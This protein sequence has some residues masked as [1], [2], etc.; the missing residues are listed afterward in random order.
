MDTMNDLT[1]LGS[2]RVLYRDPTD[3]QMIRNLSLATIALTL[4]CLC[5]LMASVYL[6]WR[7][8][9]RIVVDRS[10]G[11]VITIDNRAYGEGPSASL[12]PDRL[13]EADSLFV[14]RQFT[15]SYYGI[16]PANRAADIERCIRL[17]VPGTAKQFAARIVQ[18]RRLETER[19]ESHQATWTIQSET[20][21]PRDKFSIRVI[22]LQKLT[23][24]KD[25]RTVEVS[26]QLEVVF[27]LVADAGGRTDENLRSGFRIGR[28]EDREIGG[29]Q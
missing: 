13:T 7:R 18:D 12:M 23:S 1:V 10:S 17:M 14:V 2:E 24:V 11:Q 22:G 26:R 20:I 16:N 28:F 15:Q 21:D 6:Y 29:A 19:A 9:D 27:K 8:P 25:G 4:L 5:S 3:V